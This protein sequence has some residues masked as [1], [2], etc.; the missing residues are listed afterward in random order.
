MYLKG[1]KCHFL[2]RTLGLVG[3]EAGENGIHP[4][5]R[6]RNMI[7]QWP[8]PMT[9]D[10]VQSF[11]YLTPLLRGFIPGRAELVKIMK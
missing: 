9:W 11:C 1:L 10:D 5:L 8:T 3:L 2:D 7:M 6:K 4:S